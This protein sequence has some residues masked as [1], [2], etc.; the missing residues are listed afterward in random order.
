MAK[1]LVSYWRSDELSSGTTLSFWDGFFRELKACG[2]QVLAIN[3]AFYNIWDSNT[4]DNPLIRNYLHWEV[5]RFQPDVIITFN[6][7][8]L[9]SLVD[10]FD[11]PVVIYDGDHLDYFSDKE[12]IK[13]DIDRYKVFSIVKSWKKD[14]LDFGFKSDQIFYMP[15]GTAVQSDLTVDQTMNISF[16]GQRRWYLNNRVTEAIRNGRDLDKLYA[17]Y[18][19]YAQT[20]NFDFEKMLWKHGLHKTDISYSESDLWPIFDECYLVFAHL[21]DLGLHIGGH[22]GGW[23][24]IVDFVPQIAMCHSK[25]RIFSL[26]EN[27]MFYNSSKISLNVNHPQGRGKGFSWRCWDI[28]AS[29]A[30]LVTSTSSEL[31]ENIG[32][33]VDIPM[34]STPEEARILCK[35]LLTDDERRKDIVLAS[36]EFVDSHCRWKSRFKEME[37]ILGVPFICPEEEGSIRKLSPTIPENVEAVSKAIGK[38]EVVTLGYMTFRKKVKYTLKML[39]RGVEAV[40][41]GY[42][43]LYEMLLSRRFIGAYALLMLFLL[44]ENMIQSFGINYESY[45]PE[46]AF[47]ISFLIGICMLLIILTY[48][49][50]RKVLCLLRKLF[51]KVIHD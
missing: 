50:I 30:C 40:W 6:N 26:K 2:N 46:S 7:R 3:N 23:R 39:E 48:R 1:I 38:K 13:R 20:G 15:P 24:D 19:E 9:Q 11:G 22:E 14:Y 16:L 27:E 29:N 44:A 5:E 42:T 12:T 41:N 4:T 21:V 17:L 31:K 36:Q 10:N 33:A 8:I 34:F 32:N 45:I 51:F 18:Q 47:S 37:Q 43:K 28:M 49:P 25:S 35:K